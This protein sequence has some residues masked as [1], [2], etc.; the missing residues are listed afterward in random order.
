MTTIFYTLQFDKR[1]GPWVMHKDGTTLEPKDTW[2]D[3]NLDELLKKSLLHNDAVSYS[4]SLAHI[5]FARLFPKQKI[6]KVEAMFR[7]LLSIGE[8]LHMLI[9]NQSVRMTGLQFDT[10]CRLMNQSSVLLKGFLLQADIGSSTSMKEKKR[11]EL[12]NTCL[13][14][15]GNL[16]TRAQNRSLVYLHVSGPLLDYLP[17][18]LIRDATHHPSLETLE[19]PTSTFPPFA[20]SVDGNIGTNDKLVFQARDG[21]PHRAREFLLQATASSQDFSHAGEKKKKRPSPS[22]VVVEVLH[23]QRKRAKER[24]SKEEAEEED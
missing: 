20:A 17:C 6:W 14:A 22:A 3:G 11:K 5:N 23:R 16:L 10:L 13:R 7:S 1:S 21:V 8:K 4:I 9:L 15:L 24:D 18:S 12:R 19:L 2:N